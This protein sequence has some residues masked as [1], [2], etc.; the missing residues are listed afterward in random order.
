MPNEFD[1]ADEVEN[2]KST[3]PAEQPL[4]QSICWFLTFSYSA[5]R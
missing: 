5:S 2:L 4:L 1:E 3:F